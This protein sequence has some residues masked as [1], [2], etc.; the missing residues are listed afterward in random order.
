MAV[1]VNGDIAYTRRAADGTETGAILDR[2]RRPAPN[3]GGATRFEWSP[4]GKWLASSDA[5]SGDGVPM[6]QY[7]MDFDFRT[8]RVREFAETL[9][10]NCDGNPGAI[11]APDSTR[12]EYTRLVRTGDGIERASDIYEPF[13]LVH[14]PAREFHMWISS[15]RYVERGDWDAGEYSIV[16]I[17]SGLRTAIGRVSV[18]SPDRVLVA[19]IADSVRQTFDVQETDGSTILVGLGGLPFEF[20]QDGRYVLA[21]STYGPCIGLNVYHVADGE[22][23]YCRASAGGS[24]SPNS[25]KLA[26]VAV[27][28]PNPV[29][30]QT[31]EVWIVELDTGAERK[32]ASDLRGGLGCAKWSADSRYVAITFC[33]G[34]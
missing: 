30:P 12:F 9:P 25:R 19:T 31:A 32:M 23:Q 34:V 5:Y 3:P 8:G 10:C 26:V 20:S 4:D 21:G 29:T 14:F 11:W 1:S 2:F 18:L 7:I 6:K 16:D 24:F 22:G 17:A 15:S 28:P 13:G 27:D 33:P